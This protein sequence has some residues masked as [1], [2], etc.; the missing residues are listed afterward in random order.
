LTDAG[1]YHVVVTNAYGSAT[2]NA[3]VLE[4]AEGG[5]GGGGGGGCGYTTPPEQ[6]LL[7]GWGVLLLCHFLQRL[8]RA[9]VRP[10]QPRPEAA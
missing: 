3:A 7:I 2:S 10:L 6:L 1:S 8:Q 5:G 4:V 9:P